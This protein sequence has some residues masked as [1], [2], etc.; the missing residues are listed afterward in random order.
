MR[1]RQ[2]SR[3]NLLP[4]PLLWRE[5]ADTTGDMTERVHRIEEVVVRGDDLSEE[6]R[7]FRDRSTA[8]RYYDMPS[9]VD[10][11]RDEGDLTRDP[12]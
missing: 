5:A 9:E 1:L 3:L 12:L 6:A 11:L 8:V 7:I 4:T 10:A 2:I